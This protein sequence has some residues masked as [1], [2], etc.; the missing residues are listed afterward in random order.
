MGHGRAVGEHDPAA[1]LHLAAEFAGVDD[2]MVRVMVR[3]G[4]GSG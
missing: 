4:S 1:H 2:V 3:Y